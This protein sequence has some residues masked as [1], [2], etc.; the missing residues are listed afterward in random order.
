MG[1]V[2]GADEGQGALVDQGLE[3]DVVDGGQGQV[4]QVAREGRYGGEVAVEEDGVQCGYPAV[5]YR[6]LPCVWCVVGHACEQRRRVAETERTFDD[7]LDTGQI[8]KELEMVLGAPSLVHADMDWCW[9]S[10]RS[11]VV[12]ARSGGGPQC[13]GDVV[14]R[15]SRGRRGQGRS[16]R[17]SSAG[18]RCSAG[19]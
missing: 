3:I 4:E 8:R 2:D 17:H 18:D 10:V 13:A 11:S 6:Q 19:E 12:E 5:S 16:R 14:E 7:I 15:S 9:V 1:A